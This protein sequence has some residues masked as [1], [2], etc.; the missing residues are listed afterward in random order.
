M[1]RAATCLLLAF[2]L[3]V[4]S[5]A[6]EPFP[7]EITVQADKELG[8][9][10]QIWRF[11][12][13][14]EPNYAYMKDGKRLIGQLGDLKEGDIYFRTHNLMTTGDG[15]PALKWGSTNMYTE[16]DD[17]NPIYDWTLVDL[18]FDTYL[19]NGVR[20]Y[21][22]MGFMPEALSTN[23][24][25]YKHEWRPGF[26]YEKVYT[27]WAYPPKD[28]EKWGELCYQWAKHCVERY[29]MEEVEKWYWQTWNEPNIG[30]WQGTLE[31]FNKLHDYAIA[32]VQRAIPKA[33]V[34][35]PD[36][37]GSGGDFLLGFFDHCL[38][39]TNYATGENGTQL[40]FV[41]FHAKGHP[42]VVDGRIQM[43]IANQ[44]K[45]IDNGF[46]KIASYPELK[47]TPIVIGESD[48]EGCAACQGG[49]FTYRNG[50]V[51]SS[52]TAASFVRKHDLADRHGVNLEGALTWAFTF[53]DQAY[54][55]GFRQL[56]SNGVPL[57]V[58]NVFRMFSEMSGNRIQ[59]SSTSEVDLQEMIDVGV[60]QHP[61]VAA[62]A[63]RDGD[64]LSI[65]VWHYHDDDLEGPV[66]EVS[67]TLDHLPSDATKAELTHYR[68]DEFHS[69]AYDLWLRMG[70]PVAPNE[71]EYAEL[72]TAAEL[73]T[74]EES[75]E[76]VS[77]ENGAAR[78]AFKLPR[79]G[80]SL[81]VFDLQ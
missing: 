75:P 19:E 2:C 44:L 69:N 42:K 36:V 81:I 38:Y 22:Q 27:G 18:I 64:R 15:S 49:M 16:D 7:V 41:S 43:G 4:A 35:G 58:L 3:N 17:G 45:A 32:G 74:L 55:A 71:E 1:I 48:P 11:F 60:R 26:R 51:Y 24:T 25:P 30:Y 47:D 57:P 21:V 39:G 20:P 52:Y 28:Y 79:Q 31:E 46:R 76:E 72:Q 61:D 37:A 62:F 33:R 8:P 10:R 77:L 73:A 63:S 70:Q 9:L 59:T 40:D 14:D 13:A 68:I 66:A 67:L 50:T 34:G 29:G 56:A 80:V 6:S 65:M 54:F 53:E 12:G 23:P 78:L 5:R